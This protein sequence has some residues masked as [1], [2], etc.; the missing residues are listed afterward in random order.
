MAH[1]GDVVGRRRTEAVHRFDHT[2]D[3]GPSSGLPS[4]DEPSSKHWCGGY[5]SGSILQV[6]MANHRNNKFNSN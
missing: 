6:D 2:E 4:N 5:G 1:A 3:E